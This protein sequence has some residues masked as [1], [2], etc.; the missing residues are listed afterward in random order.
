MGSTPSACAKMIPNEQIIQTL[1][2]I[3]QR[4]QEYVV[5]KVGYNRIIGPSD[6]VPRFQMTIDSNPID[7]FLPVDLIDDVSQFKI[8]IKTEIIHAGLY[9][10]GRLNPDYL[11]PNYKHP[12]DDREYRNS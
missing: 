11:K 5:G 3:I 1:E 8:D 7:I 10:I 6:F 12:S 4:I 2:D 9:E